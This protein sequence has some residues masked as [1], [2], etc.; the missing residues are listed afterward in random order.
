MRVLRMLGFSLVLACS[1]LVSDAP[2]GG[3]QQVDEANALEKKVFELYSAGR[4]SEAIPLAQRLLIVREQ[5]L[6][7][8]NPGLTTTLNNLGELYRRQGRC[9]DAEP[10]YKRSI[11]IGEQSLGREHRDLATPLNNLASLYNNQAR[12]QEAETVYR[13]SLSI[14]EKG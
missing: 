13:R 5:A 10:L 11:A 8:N 9:S 1:L 4:Y 14:S 6:G 12:Y 7:P 2:I 3:A